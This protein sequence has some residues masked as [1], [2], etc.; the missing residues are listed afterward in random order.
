MSD[1]LKWLLLGLLTIVFGIIVLGN[2]V[3]AS[4]AVV[5]LTGILLLVAGAF[6][7]FGAFTVEGAGNKILS[8]IM[9]AIMLFLGWSFLAHPLQ[10]VISLSMLVII[11]FMAGGIARVILSFQMRGTQFFWPTLIS[12][13]LSMVLAAIIWNYATAEPAAMLNLLGIL[14]GIEMLFNG[15]GLVFMA[16]FVKGAGNELKQA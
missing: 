10:G 6:Q 2:T 9:G 5:T 15:F 11:L 7:I 12:G 1:W 16:L 4:I 3:I 13:I 8:F 14:L